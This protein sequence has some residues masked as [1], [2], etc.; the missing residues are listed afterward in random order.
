MREARLEQ[1]DER[2]TFLVVHLGL[3]ARHSVGIG[4]A[5]IRQDVVQR[6]SFECALVHPIGFL[7]RGRLTSGIDLGRKHHSKKRIRKCFHDRRTS[8]P[9]ESAVFPRTAAI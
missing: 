9:D 3:K 4:L 7:S 8:G 6:T 2:S 1:A 5:E